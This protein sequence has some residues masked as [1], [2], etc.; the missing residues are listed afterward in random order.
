MKRR[1][2]IYFTSAQK[3]EIWER[4]QRGESMSSIGR[5]FD[6]DSS[7]IYPL[8]SHAGGIRPAVR[9]RSRLALTLLEREIISRGVAA[10]HSLRSIIQNRVNAPNQVICGNNLIKAELVKKSFLASCLASHHRT[11]STAAAIRKRNHCS[12]KNS[13]DFCNTIGT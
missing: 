11:V 3:T 1:R 13:T 9:K 2:R 5:G 12:P 7:S 10:C 8:L 6:R 4:W